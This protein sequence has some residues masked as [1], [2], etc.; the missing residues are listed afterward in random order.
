MP[1]P[2]PKPSARSQHALDWLN[3][4]MA[5]L[6]TAFG[7]FVAIYLAGYGWSQG[8]IGSVLTINTVVALVSQMPAGALIDWARR[9][10]LVVTVCIVLIAAGALLI[11]L[12]PHYV[13][14]MIAEVMHGITTGAQRLALAALAL[15]A[16]A[17]LALPRSADIDYARARSSEGRWEPKPARWRELAKNRRLLIF[18]FCLLLFQ[19][20]NAS[21]LPLAG[22]RFSA[23]HQPESEVVIA[24][25]VV[26]HQV[27][28][29]L[30]AT[31]SCARP[32]SGG[33]RNCRLPVSR[34]CRYAR[35]CLRSSPV[36]GSSSA[37]RCSA[38]SPRL[39][40]AS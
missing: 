7:P 1:P 14:V 40:S 9:K 29:A 25:L 20:A 23:N 16:F 36:P 33:G 32:T 39:S 19:F 24:A 38:G 27:V 31:W 17:V 13:T 15:P 5:D 12:F 10:H 8:Q 37:C 3:F 6:Q 21:M 30:I 18:A 34:P 28:T 22:E 11:A 35:C 2:Q 26:V 4:L